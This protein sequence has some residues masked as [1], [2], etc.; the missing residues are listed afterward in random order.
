MFLEIYFLLANM[1][2]QYGKARH[3]MDAYDK[4]TSA[5][6]PEEKLEVILKVY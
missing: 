3:V 6:L 1:E 2:E 4:A 5:V